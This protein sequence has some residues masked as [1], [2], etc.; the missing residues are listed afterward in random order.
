MLFTLVLA[1]R[2]ASISNTALFYCLCSQG[3]GHANRRE[4]SPSIEA[5]YR[6]SMVENPWRE[7]EEKYQVRSKQD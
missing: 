3:R 7:L 2:Q 1:S 5:Y 4:D 6:H